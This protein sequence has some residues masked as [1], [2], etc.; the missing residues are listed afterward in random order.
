ME[1]LKDKFI[2]RETYPR[3]V[4]AEI[5][6]YASILS[7]YTKPEE[8]LGHIS[9]NHPL[10]MT[11]YGVDPLERLCVI[12]GHN[13]L[14]YSAFVPV[15]IKYHSSLVSCMIM[16]HHG[17]GGGGARKEGSGLNAY[18][19]HALR[20]EG[21]DVALYGHRHDKWAK[22]VPRIKP[23]SHGK[24]HK[25]AWVRAVD[26]KVA[27]CGTYLRTLSHSKYPT[28]SEKAGYP[29]RPIG[30]LIIRIG[31]S[32]IREGGRDNLTLKFNG[33]NE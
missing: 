6:D 10:V 24:Q 7:K 20:Y 13:Y 4:D 2:T 11:E 14:G 18:I 27:Q 19:D 8:W 31:L 32:R 9:G 23:Q 30:A 17:F 29:P 22:T 26:R 25:P 28:Y 33:S 1:D 15:S 3:M 21:W 12:L 5:E 16:A